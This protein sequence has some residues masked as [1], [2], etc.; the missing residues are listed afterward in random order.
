MDT[1][2][3]NTPVNT[4][5]E[6]RWDISSNYQTRTRK[7]TFGSEADA[8]EYRDGHNRKADMTIFKITTERVG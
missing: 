5:F 6:V 8:V 3:E 1:P 7:Q 2:I 4:V